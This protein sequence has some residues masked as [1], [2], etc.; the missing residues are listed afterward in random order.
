MSYYNV[1]FS[2]YLFLHFKVSLQHCSSSPYIH[3]NNLEKSSFKY[4]IIYKLSL[5]HYII[6]EEELIPTIILIKALRKQHDKEAKVM[7]KITEK[8]NFN[9]EHKIL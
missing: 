8:L 7:P 4:E 2:Q 5:T 3:L 6:F 9:F 1:K